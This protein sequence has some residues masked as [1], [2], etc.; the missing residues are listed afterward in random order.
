MRLVG[1]LKEICYD[2]RWHECKG[3]S[4]SGAESVTEKKTAVSRE[5]GEKLTSQPRIV[6]YISSTD[7]LWKKVWSL[8]M[9]WKLF[10]LSS[11]TFDLIVLL[12]VNS[13]VKVLLL[14]LYPK[15]PDRWCYEQR[16]NFSYL[17]ARNKIVLECDSHNPLAPEFSFKLE[18][19]LYI[20]C[21]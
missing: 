6:L 15:K 12:V 19:I 17:Q 4:K 2:A 20:K 3:L 16:W 14:R 21:E 5:L 11:T 13:S 9:I 7:I 8:N 1:C 18:H 10:C